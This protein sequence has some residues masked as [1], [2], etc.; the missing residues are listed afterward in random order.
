MPVTG[1]LF[2][3]RRTPTAPTCFPLLPFYNTV[4]GEAPVVF[5]DTGNSGSGE[6]REHREREREQKMKFHKKKP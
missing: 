3:L 1:F 5:S 2:V 4:T 6:I